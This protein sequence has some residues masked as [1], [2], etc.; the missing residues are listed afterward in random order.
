M[1]EYSKF[2]PEI[3]RPVPTPERLVGRNGKCVFGTFEDEFESMALLSVLKP[4][5]APQLMNRFRLT[6]WEATEV[7]LKEGTLLCALCDMGVFGITINVFYDKRTQKAYQWCTNLRS[8][9]TGI[10]PN[11]VGGSV[12]EG[13]T[14]DGF[15][16]YVNDF[17]N[18]KCGLSGSHADKEGR[19]I[20]YEFALSRLS[21]PSVVSIP[22]GDNR[23]LYSQKDFFKADGKIT[24]NGETLHSD[25][26]TVAIVDDH[27]GYYPRKAHYDWVT[28][29]G[30]ADIAGKREFVAVNLTRNQSVDQERYNE[31][32]LWLHGRASPL[33]PVK[34]FRSA[35]SAAARG[36]SV[37]TVTDEHD[38]VNVTFTS[39]DMTA[40][41][42]HALLVNVD[43]YIAFG[44]IQGYVRDEDGNRYVLDGLAG[45][46]ED[47]TLLL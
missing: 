37:W 18:G 20:E 41:I 47:K 27:R 3:R 31:N 32:L 6:L 22:F 34:F 25:M 44:D 43:Y 42:T 16:R 35:E 30:R 33:P 9:D 13:R 39:R 2:I 23:P 10:A 7:S 36:K 40:T 17:S 29:M 8:R 11:L 19:R 14:A 4:T 28:A 5:A 38:M 15:V 1:G 45:I 12:A 46:G 21:K 26:D 24:V